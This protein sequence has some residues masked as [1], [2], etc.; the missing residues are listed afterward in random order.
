MKQVDLL[1]KMPEPLFKELQRVCQATGREA[2][3]YINT[4]LH[5]FLKLAHFEKDL[6]VRGYMDQER[7]WE[8]V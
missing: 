7:K 6:Y 1:V 5:G 4:A 2:E 8:K 3:V